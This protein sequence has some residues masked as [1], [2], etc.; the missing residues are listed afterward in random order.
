MFAPSHMAVG[1]LTQAG[2]K[3][4]LPT[5]IVAFASMGILDNTVLWHAP[6][7]WPTNT[8]GFLHFIPYPHDVPSI[9]SLIALIIATV[10]VGILL[11]RYWWGMLWAVA[12]DIIDRIILRPTIGKEP[13]H[14]L[15]AKMTTPW[16]FGLEMA[17][18]AI[19]VYAL[20]KKDKARASD[21]DSHTAK[22]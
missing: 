9:L 16:G 3:R 19:I 22:H 20:L 18:V 6:Y 5:A 13:F 1:A 12:P 4:K 15:F 10:V 8:S 21:V 2:L 7:P 11:R 14:D 17:F